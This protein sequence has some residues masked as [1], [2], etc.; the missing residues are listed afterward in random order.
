MTC[1]ASDQCHTAGTCDTTSGSCSNPAKSN[2]ATCSDG[3]A[4]TQTDTCQAGACVGVPLLWAQQ[5]GSDLEHSISAIAGLDDGGAV[6]ALQTKTGSGIDTTV[7]RYDSLGNSL[8]SKT[9]ALAGDDILN[10]GVQSGS[11]VAF[12]GHQDSKPGAWFLA[13]NI[14]DGSTFAQT[15][16][17]CGE[18]A[19]LVDGTGYATVGG[20]YFGRLNSDGTLKTSYSYAAP[21]GLALSHLTATANGGWVLVGTIPSGCCGT[22]GYVFGVNSAGK[23]LWNLTLNDGK[24]ATSV[25]VGV[26][27]L[28]DGSVNVLNGAFSN[29]DIAYVLYMHRINTVGADMWQRDVSCQRC[30]HHSRH[31]LSGM[32]RRELRCVQ[33]WWAGTFASSLTG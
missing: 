22:N 19:I 30:Q 13:L 8:W 3:N 7:S 4:C 32:Q 11:V 15:Y 20:S 31:Q 10:D 27:A 18:S 17:A 14:A 9:F 6:V 33:C 2:G 12:V 24:D 5:V 25:P 28:P 16:G 23:N 29:P 26:A 21:V 1:S